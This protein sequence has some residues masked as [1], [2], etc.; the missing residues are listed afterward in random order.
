M[1]NFDPSFTIDDG[2]CDY[3]SCLVFGCSNP[4]ACN[5][6][7]E[8]NFDDGTCEFELPRLHAPDACNFDPEATIAG[9]CDFELCGLYRSTGRQ[10]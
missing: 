10:L 8:V 9:A 4:T 1:R 6:D 7:D 5:F 3:L 2:S